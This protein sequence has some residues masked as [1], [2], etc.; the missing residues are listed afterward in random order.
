MSSIILHSFLPILAEAENIEIIP[1]TNQEFQFR[2]VSEEF[3]HFV[4]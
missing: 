2:L 1:L 4:S 3:C